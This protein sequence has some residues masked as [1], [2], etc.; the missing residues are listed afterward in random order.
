[1][2]AIVSLPLEV[3]L[4]GLFVLGTLAGALANAAIYRLA[5]RPRPISPWLPR[6]A[7]APPRRIADY[8]PIIG[9][10]GL[11]RENG[12]H[13]RGFW[14]RPMLVEL[15][16]GLTWAGLYGWEIAR[17]GLLPVEPPQPATDALMLVLH[18]Q[19]AAHLL[20]IWLMLVASLIDFDEK[21]IPDAITVPGTLLGLVIAAAVP[22]SLLPGLVIASGE[23]FPAQ[24][25]QILG[26]STW[27]FLHV[28]SPNAWPALL[29]GFPQV[30]ALPIGLAC[31]WLW[32][33]GVMPRTWYTRHGLVRACQLCAARL[34]REGSTYRM[35]VLGMVGTAAIGGVWIL[36]GRPWI[37]L[38]T[39]LLGMAASGG[40]VWVVRV[41]GSFALGREA[42]GFGD[43]MLMAM[44][45]TFLGWQA[46][47]LVF[48]LAPVAGLVL[49][50]LQAIL[51]RDTE[52]P[53][54]PFLSLAAF[55]TIVAWQPLW[56]WAWGMFAIGGLVPIAVAVCMALTGVLL[57]AW[58]L[59][60]SSF[61]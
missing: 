15:L 39:A 61:G 28:A 56:D 12:L 5:W 36:G 16:L 48:F 37:G 13:G 38:M 10:L 35:I 58:R 17:F 2:D 52:I 14:I 25:W 22:W 60:R 19:Y 41:V 9:W 23:K 34:A 30:S 49:G 21:L 47:L 42:M 24:L 33:V 57:A 20:L 50:I 3:R 46:C 32:C 18:G 53:Y 40:I 51:F 55:G 27:P 29:G 54:G 43:V 45:G 7:E 31:W 11:R 8:V 26:P 6:P 44:I 1:M 59:I 4:A